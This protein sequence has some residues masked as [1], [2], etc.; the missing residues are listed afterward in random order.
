[1][2]RQ[3]AKLNMYLGIIGMTMASEKCS[4]FQIPIKNKIWYTKVQNQVTNQQLGS[5]GPNSLSLNSWKPNVKTLGPILEYIGDFNAR[6][7]LDHQCST[8]RLSKTISNE[9][10]LPT[11]GK[12]DSPRTENRESTTEGAT[13]FYDSTILIPKDVEERAV[14]IA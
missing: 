6:I 4:I 10:S 1:M 7:S 8:T 14:N 3:I 9:F 2:N 5:Y 12:R 11:T 13:K